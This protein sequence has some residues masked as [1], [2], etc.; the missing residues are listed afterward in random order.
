M[1]AGTSWKLPPSGAP[2]SGTEVKG[3]RLLEAYGID[4]DK[5]IKRDRLGASESGGALKDG[6]IDAFV[7]DG[8]LPTAAI[9]DLA[10]TPTR[11]WGM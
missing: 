9:M 6:K 2:G 1:H 3:L 5:D 7:W 10:A 8:G 11:W 4:P